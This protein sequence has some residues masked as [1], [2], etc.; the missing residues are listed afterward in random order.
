[1]SRLNFLIWCFFLPSNQSEYMS[2]SL[3]QSS[4]Y[5]KNNNNFLSFS[6]LLKILL[7]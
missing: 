7:N 2:T 3:N 4:I 6:T 5:P 1:M